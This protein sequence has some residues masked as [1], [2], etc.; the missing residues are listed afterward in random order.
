MAIQ[1]QQQQ[2]LNQQHPTAVSQQ[3]QQVLERLAAAPDLIF[4]K[5]KCNRLWQLR[6]QSQ[7]AS[8][9]VLVMCAAAM[10][11]GLQKLL[12]YLDC[13]SCNINLPEKA[14]QSITVSLHSIYV[15]ATAR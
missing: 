9:D 5:E 3:L 8:K 6:Q 1:Q 10:S 7:P 2:Q 12:P 15:L 14:I 11:N 4:F 13:G